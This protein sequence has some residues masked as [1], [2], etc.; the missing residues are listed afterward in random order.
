DHQDV[1]PRRSGGRA[2]AEGH[3]PATKHLPIDVLLVLAFVVA[4]TSRGPADLPDHAGLRNLHERTVEAAAPRRRTGLRL[5]HEP[6]ARVALTEVAHRAVVDQVQGVVGTEHRRHWPVDAA[7]RGDLDER[8]IPD[9]L[10]AGR[11]VGVVELI[12]LLAVER[13]PRLLEV[14]ALTGPAEVHQLDVVA[15]RGLAV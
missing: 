14:E 8:L 12:G 1:T 11:A 15:R 10:A 2:V 4:V 9:G 6:R 7:Q 3:R 13:E 5:V